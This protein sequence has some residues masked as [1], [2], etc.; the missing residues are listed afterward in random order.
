MV[1]FIDGE[2][3]KT[4]YRHFRIRQEKGKSDTDSMFEVARRRA[5]YLS[6]WGTANL[7][8]VDGGRPQVAAFVKVFSKYG[9]PVIGLAKREEKLVIPIERHD[10][11]TPRFIERIVP[12]GPAR[13]LLQRIRNEAHRFALAFHTLIRG[14]I[15]G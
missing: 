9:I 2:A 7:I 15:K 8:I 3:E 5:K 12:R 6:T 4:L 14:K 13:N 11:S 1:T 10:L